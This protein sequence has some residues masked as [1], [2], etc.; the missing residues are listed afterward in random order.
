MST[1]EIIGDAVKSKVI[2]CHRF[3][4]TI[5]IKKCRGFSFNS[6]KVHASVSIP[7]KKMESCESFSRKLRFSLSSYNALM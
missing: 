2:V 3:N 5:S 7:E 4:M 1:L 6:T